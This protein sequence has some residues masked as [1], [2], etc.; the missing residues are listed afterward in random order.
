MQEVQPIRGHI[1]RR[2]AP[3]GI[4]PG[5]NRNPAKRGIGLFNNRVAMHDPGLV[6]ARE[7]EKVGM[8]P[9]ECLFSLQSDWQ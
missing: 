8:A 1:S 5:I 7:A 4:G 6:G 2:Q 3:S 9:L